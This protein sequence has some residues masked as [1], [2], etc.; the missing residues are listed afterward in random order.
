M[1]QIIDAFLGPPGN[2]SVDGSSKAKLRFGQSTHTRPRRKI[3]GHLLKTS[4]A[5]KKEIHEKAATS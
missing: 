5:M 1:I 2:P 3:V 4:T